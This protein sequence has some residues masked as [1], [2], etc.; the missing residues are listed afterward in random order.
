M[1]LKGSLI[2]AAD[3]EEQ[4]TD[5]AR[6]VTEIT[7]KTHLGLQTTCHNFTVDD[8]SW[9]PSVMGRGGV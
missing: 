2:K 3:M 6:E 9:K 5:A 8:Q 1:K 4:K 7:R